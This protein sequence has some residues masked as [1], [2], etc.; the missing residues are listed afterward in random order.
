MAYVWC[1]KEQCRIPAFRCLLCEK[2]CYPAEETAGRDAMA[3]ELLLRTGKYEE[4]F[5][6]KRKEK[7]NKAEASTPSESKKESLEKGSGKLSQENQEQDDQDLFLLDNGE[8]K[9]FKSEDYTTSTLYQRLESFSVECKLVRPEDPANLLYEGRKPS[10]KTIPIVVTKSN[11]CLLL[12]SWEQLES[13]PE[14]LADAAEVIGAAPVKQVFVL[15][16]K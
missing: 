12:D 4:R 10:K 8:L 5:V 3:L 2:E 9:P 11:G 14:Q 13:N 6:M 7:V 16:R 15:K 1:S